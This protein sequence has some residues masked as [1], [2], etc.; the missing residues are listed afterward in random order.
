MDVDFKE[1]SNCNTGESGG[2]LYSCTSGIASV[3]K[4]DGLFTCQIDYIN[5]KGKIS[6]SNCQSKLPFR[7]NSTAFRNYLNELRWGDNKKIFFHKLGDCS[8]SRY[9][10]EYSCSEGNMVIESWRGVY[11]CDVEKATYY[12]SRGSSRYSRGGCMKLDW[13]Q[14]G[15]EK[16]ERLG[17]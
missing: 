10:S 4:Q 9:D 2:R 3:N 13:I 8:Y 14:Q 1:V 16:L 7:T 17:I 11:R 15:K 6:W 5:W 12:V